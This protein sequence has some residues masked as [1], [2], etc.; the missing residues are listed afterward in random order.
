MIFVNNRLNLACV[1]FICFKLQILAIEWASVTLLL[2]KRW[3]TW[4]GSKLILSAWWWFFFPSFSSFLLFVSALWCFGFWDLVCEYQWLCLVSWFFA[5]HQEQMFTKQWTGWIRE[6][7]VAC[8]FTF[9]NYC[10]KF[11]MQI[12]VLIL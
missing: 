5:C 10:G 3:S 6:V 9:P 2:R 1:L 11:Q 8:C 7:G 12:Y 4:M